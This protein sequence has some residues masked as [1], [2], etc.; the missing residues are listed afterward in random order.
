MNQHVRCALSALLAA[1]S[2]SV[3]VPVRAEVTLS[4]DVSPASPSDPW[5]LGDSPLLVGGTIP[6][7]P[8]SG[9]V[10]V[11]NRGRV[12]SP[13]AIIGGPYEGSGAVEV[14]GYGSRWTNNGS[15][16]IGAGHFAWGSLIVRTG[17]AVITDDLLVS[18]PYFHAYGD[19]LVEGYD[20]TLTSRTNAYIGDLWGGKIEIR[21]GASFFSHN[22]YFGAN[23]PEDPFRP[24]EAFVTGSATRWVSTGEFV[25][26]AGRAAQLSIYRGELST[27]DAQVLGN[28]LENSVVSV[29]GWGGTWTNAGLLSVGGD[30]GI[31]GIALGALGTLA[32]EQ[33]E[34]RSRG[35]AAYIYV[36]DVYAS[37]INGGDVT[38]LASTDSSVYP[39]LHIDGG[40]SVRIGG[41]LRLA[42]LP[43][44]PGGPRWAV[45]LADGELIA[46]EIEVQASDVIDFY[47]GRLE[48]SSFT[49]DLANPALGTL[50]VGEVYPSTSVAGSYSQ[51]LF[52]ALSVT[53]AGPSAAPLLFVDGDV[54]LDGALEIHVEDG[55]MPF[56]A[57]D[58]V[59]VLGWSG[60]LL[61]TFSE[62]SVDVPLAPGLAWDTSALYTTGEI[63][64]VPG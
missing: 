33:A 29:S 31:G 41:L 51:G 43:G 38:I 34:I 62:V 53:V 1:V 63:V 49:G 42:P 56:E 46:G 17:A 8:R 54:T 21:K 44:A 18:G 61:G 35:G 16:A 4:D 60:A 57:G 45:R 19:V 50:V 28:E 9:S 47:R 23:A 24:I 27:V 20:A 58:T 2:V 39:A 52:A 5:D 14:V 55:A 10:R 6:G 40:G 22:V 13:G 32:T 30:D 15:L 37:W 12:L 25:V 36:T 3:A 64:V 26:G 48:T 7:T 11:S 59:A